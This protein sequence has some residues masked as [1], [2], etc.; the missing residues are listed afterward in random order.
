[1]SSATPRG[2]RVAIIGAGMA[3]TWCAE[4][5]RREGLEVVVFDKARGT[6]GR[7]STR[8]A[9]D[10]QFDHGAQYFTARDPLF[11]SIVSEWVERGVVARWNARIVALTGGHVEPDPRPGIRY[12]GVPTM[13]SVQRHLA[14]DLAVQLETRITRIV[15]SDRGWRLW[16][17]DGTDCGEHDV[18]VCTQPPEQIKPLYHS[19]AP[20]LSIHLG[21]ARMTGC[22]AVMVT[23]A[24]PM[25]VE[26]DAAFVR[27]SALSWI[28]NDGSK[29]QRPDEHN[30]VLHAAPDWS[31]AHLDDDPAEQLGPLL[32]AMAEALD[33]KNPPELPDVIHAAAHRWRYAAP[34]VTIK[35]RSLFDESLGLGAAGDWCNGPRVEGSFLSGEELAQRILASR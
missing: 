20:E 25:P 16:S 12:V 22:I 7:M 24:D 11:R 3:G 27:G 30:W 1:M 9:D 19:I 23:F 28:A 26:F 21:K 33:P 2:K 17:E 10:R 34:S 4:R 8:R 31:D 18:V 15:R 35:R 13:N 14:R 6:G 32:R 29:P 5:L